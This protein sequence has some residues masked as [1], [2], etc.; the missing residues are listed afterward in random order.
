LGLSEVNHGAFYNGKWQSTNSPSILTTINP[1]TEEVLATTH[2]GSVQD[3]DQAV[4]AM[5]Q[6]QR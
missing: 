5:I 3:Y 4:G 6:A 2:A 1:A